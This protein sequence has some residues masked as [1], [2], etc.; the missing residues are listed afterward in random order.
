MRNGGTPVRTLPLIRVLYSQHRSQDNSFKSFDV[1]LA[2]KPVSWRF[3]VPEWSQSPSV[4]SKD[5]DEL[6][7][8][9]SRKKQTETTTEKV[10]ICNVCWFPWCKYTPMM[11]V[12]CEVSV[13][14]GGK[15][16]VYLAFMN[17][18]ELV[19]AAPSSHLCIWCCIPSIPCLCLYV[20]TLGPLLLFCWKIFSH[21]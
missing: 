16:G 12:Q 17:L 7:E 8:Q 4:N 15:R 20:L 3:P 6:V 2:L 9:F 10:L 13:S 1:I 14:R 11:A 19:Q 5:S 21:H 18:G